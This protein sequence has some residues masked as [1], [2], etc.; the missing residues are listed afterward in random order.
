M[1]R[2][3]KRSVIIWRIVRDH[4]ELLLAVRIR[5]CD[6]VF[7]Y[8]VVLP[9]SVLLVGVTEKE[10]HWEEFVAVAAPSP[11]RIYCRSAASW[12]A[13]WRSIRVPMTNA[14]ASKIELEHIHVSRPHTS[15]HLFSLW[16]C[17]F[18]SIWP[19]SF[20]TTIVYVCLRSVTQLDY[21]SVY[22]APIS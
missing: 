1:R 19:F 22:V 10:S 9:D 6:S 2:K 7:F 12:G 11:L 18:I 16:I 20:F 17:R 13:P 3:R 4:H 15:Q 21:A 8:I 14:S 5:D